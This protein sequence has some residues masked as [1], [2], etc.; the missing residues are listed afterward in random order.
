MVKKIVIV[1]GGSSGWMTAAYLSKHLEGIELVV[2]ESS[3]IPIIGVGESTIPPMKD[4]MEAL[5]LTEAEWMPQC[6]ATYKS[7]I[8]FQDF[9][10]VGEPDFWYSFEPLANVGGRPVSRYWYNKHLTRPEF[11][12]RNTFFDWCFLAPEFSRQN[13]TLTSLTGSGPAYQVDAGLMGHLYRRLDQA[14]FFVAE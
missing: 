2:I 8:R 13:K 10:D 14:A 5:D 7:A 9:Y 11:A 12:D 4:F 3:D 6:N 1:G